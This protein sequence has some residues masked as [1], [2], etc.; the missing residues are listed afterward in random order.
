MLIFKTKDR[1]QTEGRV[2]LRAI[3]DIARFIFEQDKSEKQESD[4]LQAIY[5]SP[6]QIQLFFAD[7]EDVNDANSFNLIKLTLNKFEEFLSKESELYKKRLK[8]EV[9]QII[10]GHR[11]LQKDALLKMVTNAK[12]VQASLCVYGKKHF[13][14]FSGTVTEDDSEWSN[15]IFITCYKFIGTL[16]GISDA[17][18]ENW[19]FTVASKEAFE[20]VTNL[21]KILNKHDIDDDWEKITKYLNQET[22]KVEWK[23]TFFTPSTVEKNSEKFA[24]LSKKLFYGIAKTILAM[25]NTEGGVILVGLVENPEQIVVDH[26]RKNILRKKSRSFFDVSQELEENAMDLD[27]IKRKM[28]DVLKREDD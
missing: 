3:D 23:S 5:G 21:H 15:K 27:G 10:Q 20:W 24:E 16:I 12:E 25:I 22:N 19:K 28:Q 11:Q 17:F 1:N 4:R 26:I 9:E 18:D 6:D 7:F 14:A 13:K 2:S 8:V